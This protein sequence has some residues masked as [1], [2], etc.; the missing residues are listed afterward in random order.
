MLTADTHFQFRAGLAAIIDG[1]LHQLAHAF[2]V[3]GLERILRQDAL[4]DICDQEVALGIVT[5]VAKGHLGQVVGAEGE[6]LGQLGNFTG[7][8]CRARDLDHGAE[9]VSEM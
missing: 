1:H 4:A 5:A 6:E 8:H 2:P 7:G 9:F 3:Q